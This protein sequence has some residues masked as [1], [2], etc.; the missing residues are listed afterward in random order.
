MPGK[1]IYPEEM[2]NIQETI[3]EVVKS[4]SVLATALREVG[5]PAGCPNPAAWPTERDIVEARA[6]IKLAPPKGAEFGKTEVFYLDSQAEDRARSVALNAAVFKQLRIRFQEL[7]DAKAQSMIDE[8]TKTVHLAQTDLDQATAALTAT[9]NRVGSDL[10]ELR[11][12]QDVASSD[13]ALRR[14]AEEIRAQLRENAATEK[15]DLQLLAVLAGAEDDPGRLV[16][17]PNRLLESHPSLNQL[18]NGLIEAQLRTA[19]LLGTMSA[20]HPLVRAAKE[21]EEQIGR[22]LHNELAIAR[23]GVEVEVRLTADRRALL[24]DQLATTN[25]RLQRLAA[26]RPATPTRWPK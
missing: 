1:F 21:S 3:L 9:E 13:S 8:L 15:T 17:T 19:K 11:S 23:R 4:R 12:M 25:E 2:K 18:K 20:Q 16:A 14:S 7:R 10:A 22:D 6:N 26:V 5:P 24:E